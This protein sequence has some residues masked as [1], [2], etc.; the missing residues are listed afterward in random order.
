[1]STPGNLDETTRR[2]K[3]L[4]GDLQWSL[5]TAAT[6]ETDEDYPWAAAELRPVRADALGV[7]WIEFGNE[8]VLS[9]ARGLGGRWEPDRS[10]ESMEFLEDV[11]RSVVAGRVVEVTAGDRS[12]IQVTLSDGSVAVETGRVGVR[13][14]L[15]KPGWRRWGRRIRY[16]P[17]LG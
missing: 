10:A 6:V 3:D 12:R 16:A 5:G 13:S 9:T 2:L 11:V 8:V 14:L 17:Y 15:P 1:M 7:S 4:A